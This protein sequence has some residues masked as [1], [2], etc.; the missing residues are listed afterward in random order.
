[1]TSATGEAFSPKDLDLFGRCL[2]RLDDMLQRAKNE[3]EDEAV[4]DSVIKRFEL[5]YE[6]AHRTLTKFLVATAPS[7][8]RITGYDFQ[9]LI[10]KGDQQRLLRTG[11]PEWK[12]FRE[13]RNR[14]VHTYREEIAI[15]VAADAREFALEGRV[16][17]NNISQRMQADA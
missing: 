12:R 17:F 5:A 2:D 4:R 13:A 15:E 8:E 7:A 14:T 9:D 3:P 11:W 16:L 10:R 6:L 1:M